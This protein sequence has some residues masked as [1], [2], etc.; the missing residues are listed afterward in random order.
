MSATHQKTNSPEIQGMNSQAILVR[1]YFNL[2][3]VR[4]YFN[5]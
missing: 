4:L 5:S 1:L 2:I 3:L